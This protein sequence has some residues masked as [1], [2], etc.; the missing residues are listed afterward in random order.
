[1]SSDLWD[2][3]MNVNAKVPVL[4]ISEILN[5]LN[6]GEKASVVNILDQKLSNPN[7]D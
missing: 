2:N 7:P 3:H 1:M 5:S 4:L 6:D